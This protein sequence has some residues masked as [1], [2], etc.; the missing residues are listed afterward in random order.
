MSLFSKKIPKACPKC[1]KADAGA[2]C[3]PKH[4]RAMWMHRRR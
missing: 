3:L 2:V 4:T 1:G